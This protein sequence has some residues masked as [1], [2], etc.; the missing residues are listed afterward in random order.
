M[1]DIQ[2]PAAHSGPLP[3]VKLRAAS[4]TA[5]LYKRMI[6]ETDPKARPGDLVAVYDKSGAP[7]GSPSTTPRASSPCAF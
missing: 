6:G 3:W 7:M 1:T 2:P 5:N 4:A